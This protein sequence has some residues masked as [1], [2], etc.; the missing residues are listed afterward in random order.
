MIIEKFTIKAQDAIEHACRLAVKKEHQYVTPWHLLYSMMEQKG[1]PAQDFLKKAGLETDAL[2]ARVEGQLLTQPKAHI[3]TQQTP[4]NRDLEKVFIH[5]EESANSLDDK[6]IDINHILMGMLEKQEILSAFTEAGANKPD[7]LEI[8]KNAPKSRF[9]QGEGGPAEFEYLAKYTTDFTERA[10]E[11]KIDP[12]IGRD[13]EIRQVIQ[14]L[15]RR[16]KSNPIVIGE[17]GVGKTAVVEGLAQRIVQGNVPDNLKSMSILGL[18]MGQLI[19]GAKYRGEFEERFKRVLQEIADAENIIM[20]IDEIHML[21][22]AGGGSEGAMD[23]SN[24]IKPALSRGEIRCLGATTLEEYRKHIE[25]DAALMRRFQIVMIK[26]PSC[27]ETISILRGV[28]EKYEVHH[29]VRITDAA[30]HAAIN[31]SHRYITD[32]FLPDKALDLIDQ[33]AAST[34][35]ILSSKPEELENIDRRIVQLEIEI[36][37]LEGEEAEKT[38]KHVDLLNQ[39]MESLKEKSQELTDKWQKEKRAIVEVQEAKKKL[40]QARQEMEQKIREEDFSRVA[41]LQYKVIPECEN[42]L[43]QYAD[44]DLSDSRLLRESIDEQDV[45]DT[46]SQWTGIPVSKMLASDQQRFLNLES[47]LRKRVVGQDEALTT[48]ARAVRRSRAAVQ[49]PDRPIASFLMLGPTGVG[50]TEVSKALSEFLFD[51]ERAMIR[52]DMSEFM[53][54]HAA[55]RLVGAP[56]GYVGYEE[57]GILTNKVRRKPYSVILFDEV[58]KAHPDVFNL[59]LQLMDDGRLTDSHGQTVN[60]T[61]TIVLMTSNLGAEHIEPAQTQEEIMQMKAGIMQAVRSHFRPEFLN[62]LDDIL[63]FS[64]LTMDVMIPIAEIQLAR[65]QNLLKD[66]EIKLDISQEAKAL[67]AQ[68]GFNPLMG[69][70]PLKRVIQSCLQDPLAEEIISGTIKEGDIITI[71]ASEQDIIITGAD[72][73]VLYPKEDNIDKDDYKQ[74]PSSESDE[75]LSQD[76]E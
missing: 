30:I 62:R 9:K 58:E 35:I 44:I 68:Q 22:G 13:E 16:L 14:V 56:P 15:S 54:K 19:A 48:I 31:L 50:K 4:I 5:S 12:V 71:S 53:E 55:A 10:R 43:E 3:D 28:K 67:L 7:L 64:Q 63:V 52:I 76:Q 51:D 61:N 26:E 65:L 59:F 74:E 33:T 42:I 37:A 18:D 6:Y 1:N 25:K 45:A 69:A 23:A 70:R 66:R 41:E 27:E 8:L 47:L 11:G 39:E 17:P 40:D 60:F 49:D 57:G 38:I 34:R 72:G 21:I 2:R 29:G 24:L 32:R 36:R 20:F 75:N 73:A 46:V